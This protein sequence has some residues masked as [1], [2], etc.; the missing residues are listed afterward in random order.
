MFLFGVQRLISETRLPSPQCLAD[1]GRGGDRHFALEGQGPEESLESV[2]FPSGTGNTLGQG[3]PEEQRAQLWTR[4]SVWTCSIWPRFTCRS[5]Q[6][7]TDL[8]P[9]HGQ[10]AILM[11]IAKGS[12][13]I[14]Q[15]CPGGQLLRNPSSDI[16]LPAPFHTLTVT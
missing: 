1:E 12:L 14:I 2:H 10:R 9:V 7:D 8:P 15:G 3:Q 4:W 11:K 16:K 5:S 13:N 6:S